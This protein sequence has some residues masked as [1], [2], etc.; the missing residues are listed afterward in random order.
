[1]SKHKLET[2]NDGAPLPDPTV[3]TDRKSMPS[4]K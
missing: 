4:D 1:M 2:E 3:K